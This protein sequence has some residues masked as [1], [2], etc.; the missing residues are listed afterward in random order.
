M[1]EGYT[2]Q[3]LL[4][5]I[6]YLSFFGWIGYRRGSWRE[7]IVLVMAVIGW[8]VLQEQGDIFVRIANLGSKFTAFITAGGLSENPEDAFSA[9]GDASPWV[10]SD[11]QEWIPFR[12]LGIARH[13]GL[14]AD[15]LVGALDQESVQWLGDSV[16]HAEW[17]VFRFCLLA[18][19]ALPVC[20]RCSLR[21]Y[22]FSA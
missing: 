2:I 22:Y 5:F 13:P 16:G 3:V 15:R 19:T 8:L 7:F 4:T 17:A 11:D 1:T 20:T 12:D 14:R 6:L 9:I 18:A 10:T 21:G